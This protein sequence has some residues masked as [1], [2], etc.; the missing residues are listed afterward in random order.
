MAAGVIMFVNFH[1][2]RETTEKLMARL[3]TSAEPVVLDDLIRYSGHRVSN[4]DFELRGMPGA[5]EFVITTNKYISETPSFLAPYMREV[6]RVEI[7]R[8]S[9]RLTRA[10]SGYY[11]WPDEHASATVETIVQSSRMSDGERLRTFHQNITVTARELASLRRVHSALCAG[12]ASDYC[13]D[14]FE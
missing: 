7:V 9:C 10:A 12:E 14:A 8:Y 13:V 1:L 5:A 6:L 4:G 3:S 2:S 11:E